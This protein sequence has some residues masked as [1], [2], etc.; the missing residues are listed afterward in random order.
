MRSF[1]LFAATGDAVARLDGSDSAS[2]V[3]VLGLEG[4]GAQC[5]AVDPHDPR[6]VYVGTFDDGVYRSLDAGESTGD[7]VQGGI[8]AGDVIVGPGDRRSSA[9]GEG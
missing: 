2:V 5:V 1:R 3:T 4:S 9:D 8:E 6:R 7:L